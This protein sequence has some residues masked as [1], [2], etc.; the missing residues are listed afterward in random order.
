[1]SSSSIYMTYY[2]NVPDKVA[3]RWKK[4][5]PGYDVELSLDEDCICFLETHFNKQVADMFRTIKEGIY[6]SDLWRL[7]KLY[8]CGG[9]YT[10]V[11]IV[12]YLTLDKLDKHITF[13]SCLAVDKRSIF[14]AFMIN[15]SKPRNKL[16]LVFILSFLLNR[17]YTYSNGPT[18]DMYNCLTYM[19]GTDAILSNK[20]Y[21]ITNP[22]LEVTIGTSDSPIKKINLIYFPD[23]VNYY[24]VLHDNPYQDVFRFDI[25][26]NELIIERKDI[27]SGWGHSHKVDICFISKEKVFLFEEIK[28]HTTNTFHVF[29]N[30]LKIMDS[31]DLDYVKNGGKW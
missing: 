4:L 24:V 7:C 12:P 8:V 11:D 27:A 17:P 23:D 15:F 5:N 2:K 29:D 22:K 19:T 25:K 18:Y 26:D 6:K 21:S 1:M 3:S 30:K 13:Y 16:L 9:V 28:D 31:R 14:Q 10:D 20:T